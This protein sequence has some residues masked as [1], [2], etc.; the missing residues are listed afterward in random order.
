MDDLCSQDY[1]NAGRA[2]MR[3]LH[4]MTENEMGWQS[5]WEEKVN[6]LYAAIESAIEDLQSHEASK[7]YARL[8]IVRR[9]KTALKELD[10]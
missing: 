10:E 4:D 3:G 6:P 7:E 1:E 8:D 5:C 2:I 9:L